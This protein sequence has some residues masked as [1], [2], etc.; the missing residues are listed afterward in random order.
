LDLQIFQN[1]L[2]HGLQIVG[3]RPHLIWADRRRPSV[4]LFQSFC[5][6]ANA[7]NLE[8]PRR[9]ICTFNSAWIGLFTEEVVCG[10][11]GSLSLF[12][13]TSSTSVK[14]VPVEDGATGEGSTM[15]SGAF[16]DGGARCACF[17]LGF[18]LP[19]ISQ[20]RGRRVGH[21][22][23]HGSHGTWNKCRPRRIRFV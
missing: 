11:V 2:V 3:V 15:L 1:Q 12:S 14:S 20:G 9:D 6:S 17:S 5:M 23:S 7:F 21:R 4:L 22:Y 18:T 16:G 8:T 19:G 13:S 10:F